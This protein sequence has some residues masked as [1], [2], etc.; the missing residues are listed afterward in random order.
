MCVGF[1]LAE[2]RDRIAGMPGKL[3]DPQASPKEHCKVHVTRVCDAVN[4]PD[5]DMLLEVLDVVTRHWTDEPIE[6]IPVDRVRRTFSI[7]PA[8]PL[9][10]SLKISRKGTVVRMWGVP[11]MTLGVSQLALG[12][13]LLEDIKRRYGAETTFFNR[14]LEAI[15]QAGA[16]DQLTQQFAFAVQCVRG[17]PYFQAYA[18]GAPTLWPIALSALGV[19]GVPHERAGVALSDCGDNDGDGI[20]M[21]LVPGKPPTLKLYGKQKPEDLPKVLAL[22]PQFAP[23]FAEEFLKLARIEHFERFGTTVY[24]AQDPATPL[25]VGLHGSHCPFLFDGVMSDGEASKLLLGILRRLDLDPTAYL[26]ALHSIA[27]TDLSRE[28]GLQ[29][30]FIVQFEKGAPVLNVYLSTR[31]FLHSKAKQ[32]RAYLGY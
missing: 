18:A 24:V 26:A 30:S 14:V 19:E 20:G 2:F 1:R 7:D 9:E 16:A 27:R 23:G 11:S 31:F 4:S 21:P 6:S 12:R 8:T 32:H 10:I 17:R 28:Y 29:G 13:S 5:R 25:R 15:E 22:D 3:W